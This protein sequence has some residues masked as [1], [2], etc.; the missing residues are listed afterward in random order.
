MDTCS[1]TIGLE[2]FSIS[3][4]HCIDKDLFERLGDCKLI[5]AKDQNQRAECGCIASI[6][7][8]V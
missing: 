6:D 8:G 2:Q 7:M 4:A 3:H 1:E 5:V